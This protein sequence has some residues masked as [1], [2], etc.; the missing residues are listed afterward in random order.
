MR[1]LVI[2]I[3]SLLCVSGVAGCNA[4]GSAPAPATTSAPPAIANAVAPK[5]QAKVNLM[6]AMPP[7]IVVYTSQ[8]DGKRAVGA[9]PEDSRTPPVALSTAGVDTTFAA[10][11]GGRRALLV[12]HAADTSIAALVAVRG[13]GAERSS[14]GSFPLAQYVAVAQAKDAGDATVVELARTGSE[15]HDVFALQ[16]SAPPRLLAA[17]STLVAVAAGRAAVS[18][19]G[20]LRSMKLDGSA[21]IALGPGDGRDRVADVKGDRVL[22]TTHGGRGGDVRVIGIDGTNPV[23]VGKPNVDENAVSLTAQRILFVRTTADGASIVS[24]AL[25]GKDE[26]VLT[27]PALGAAPIKVTADGQV[28]FGNAAGALYAVAATGG[29]TRLLDPTAG[30]NVV[31]SAVQAG[32]VVYR[33]DTPHWPALRAVKLDGTGLVSLVEAVPQVPF[34]ASLTSDGRVVYYRSLSG[35]LEGGAI[36]SVKLDGTDVR[37]LGTTVAGTDG[38]PLPS[39]PVDQDFEGVTPSGRL[40]LESEFSNMNGSQLVVAAGDH[41]GAQLLPGASQV[42]FAALI[43]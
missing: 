13:D 40:I 7:A 5:P 19:G 11:I 38:M 30:T 31:I 32:M 18:T 37:P 8:V 42:R 10:V 34:F 20:N 4:K 36:F 15:V 41:D 27:P 17:A 1:T 3:S 23:A 21:T 33:C 25:D 12:E 6:A 29:A 35:Q 22:Y 9:T 16:T 14:L 26:Q 2:A 28:L 24:T 43:P 39:G